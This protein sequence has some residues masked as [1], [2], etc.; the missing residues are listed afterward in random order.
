[1]FLIYLPND[2]GG[3]IDFML[4][5]LVLNILINGTKLAWK[6][7]N[8]GKTILMNIISN[9]L[10]IVRDDFLILWEICNHFMFWH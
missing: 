9:C 1:M 7:Q 3:N 2:G 5:L 10:V 8:D 4:R 6:K